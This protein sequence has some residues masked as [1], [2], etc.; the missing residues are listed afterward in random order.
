MRHFLFA[1]LLM[2]SASFAACTHS[3]PAKDKEAS[4]PCD[5]F[6]EGQTKWY[7]GT[8]VSFSDLFYYNNTQDNTI[9][10][11]GFDENDYE[12]ESTTSAPSLGY[13][14]FLGYVYNPFL[15]VEF[16]IAQILRPFKNRSNHDVSTTDPTDDTYIE[17]T[18]LYILSFGPYLLINLPMYKAFTPYFRFGMVTD[19]VTFKNTS[20]EDIAGDSDGT[21]ERGSQKQYFWAEKF[22]VGLGFKSSWGKYVTFRVEYETPTANTIVAATTTSDLAD[23]YI[24]GILSASLIV[25][26]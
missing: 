6:K 21:L 11:T 8:G 16:K 9:A 26:F 13:N 10:A 2:A 14:A 4:Q 25:Q 12:R 24:P 3:T 18:K 22:H 5:F 17:T 7:I 19:L 15:D 1:S 20:N 23:F